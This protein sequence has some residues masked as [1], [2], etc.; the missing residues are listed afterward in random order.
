[1]RLFTCLFLLFIFASTLS[2]SVS[3]EE[4][5]YKNKIEAPINDVHDRVYEALEKQRFWNLWTF[6]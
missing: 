1:M 5:I 3:A 2:M 6:Q 4:A